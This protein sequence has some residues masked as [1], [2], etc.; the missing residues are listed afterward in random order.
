MKSL[1]PQKLFKR[2]Q[3][4]NKTSE[5]SIN[6][7]VEKNQT[8]NPPKVLHLCKNRTHQ[9]CWCT[10]V[11]THIHTLCYSKT[12]LLLGKTPVF[13]LAPHPRGHRVSEATSHRAEKWTEVARLSKQRGEMVVST[14]SSDDIIELTQVKSWLWQLGK[15][16]TGPN[17]KLSW[18]YAFWTKMLRIEL[19]HIQ[20]LVYPPLS[21]Y[22]QIYMF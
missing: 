14:I 20:S 3:V 6:P 7:N 1:Q 5:D 11:Q 2:E 13:V 18:K 19:L 17:D 8:K 22:K 15:I 9:A 4:A 21:L 12:G 10:H 16:Y